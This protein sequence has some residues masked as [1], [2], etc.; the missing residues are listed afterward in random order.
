MFT[1]PPLPRRRIKDAVYQ[2]MSHAAGWANV[3]LEMVREEGTVCEVRRSM[4]PVAQSVSELLAETWRGHDWKT[5]RLAY[6]TR[7]DDERVR[8][9]QQAPV[10]TQLRWAAPQLG[11]TYDPT[12]AELFVDIPRTP[13]TSLDDGRTRT[14]EYYL[15]LSRLDVRLLHTHAQDENNPLR[16]NLTQQQ[17]LR[18]MHRLQA[19]Y[20]HLPPPAADADTAHTAHAPHTPP[21]P[22]ASPATGKCDARG[23]PK[24]AQMRHFLAALRLC[25]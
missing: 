9:S 15:L 12:I 6:G 3:F 19:L 22:D 21:A 2:V 14:T 20:M 4:V 5:Y 10:P 18:Q 24:H 25:A 17:V 13:V 8:A 7:L 11:D 23:D 1:H 16:L